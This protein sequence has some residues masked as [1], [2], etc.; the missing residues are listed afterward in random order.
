MDKRPGR[1]QLTS[2]PPPP[3]LSTAGLLVL[4][5]V[6]YPASCPAFLA[7]L[8][9]DIASHWAQAHAAAASG[10]STHKDTANASLLVRLYYRHRLFMGTCC[11]SCEVLYLALYAL[12]PRWAARGAGIAPSALGV[13]GPSTRV[14]APLAS[15]GLRLGVPGAVSSGGAWWKAGGGGSVSTLPAAALVAAIT[16]PGVAIKQFVN[17]K[18]LVNAFGTLASLDAADGGGGGG[19]VVKNGG[20]VA[21]ASAAAAPR[22]SR[23]RSKR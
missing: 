19:A 9:L 11:V 12:A 14:P 4:L 6:Q 16:L 5:C 21:A 13:R 8:A 22:R 23:S 15:L 7:L 10:A 3:S 18:Q 2:P 17:W 1:T 20:T